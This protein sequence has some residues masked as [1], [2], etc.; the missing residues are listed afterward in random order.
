M[1]SIYQALKEIGN[2]EKILIVDDEKVVRDLFVETLTLFGYET[3]TSSSGNDCIEKIK[4]GN[5]YDVVLLDVQ[6]PDKD[7]IATLEELMELSPDLS[8][9]MVSASRNIEHVRSTLTKGAYDYIFKPFAIEEVGTVVRRA[10]ERSNLVKQNLDYQRNLEDK[11]ISQTK[12]LFNLYA[13]T[14]EA[15]VLALDLRE[16]ETGF[17]SYRVTEYALTLARMLN[18]SDE[19][20][21]IIAKGALLHDIGKIGVPDN[22][23]LKPDKLN[24]EEWSV[25][26]KHTVFGYQLLQKIEFLEQAAQIV[27]HHHEHYDGSGYP[28]GISGE[29][30][31]VGARIFTV[32]DALDA[33]T[34]QRVYKEAISFDE[35]KEIIISESGKQ[36]DPNIIKV[37]E[38]TPIDQFTRVKDEIE[39]TGTMYLRNLLYQM[40]KN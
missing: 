20:L 32:V 26:K 3:E 34:C 13:D 6:M 19:E 2:K 25:M 24:D 5:E 8:I 35:A 21:S 33:L 27:L 11:V 1:S 17:H 39:R 30:I 4:S 23:L 15:M 12:E 10:V 22:I 18:A 7:G 29:K 16:K 9:I 40:S 38:E 36:F 37:F 28:H 14:L 31:P